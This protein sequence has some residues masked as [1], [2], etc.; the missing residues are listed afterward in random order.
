MIALSEVSAVRKENLVHDDCCQT[1]ASR[2]ANYPF[3]MLLEAYELELR[4]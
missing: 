4:Y 3:L 2:S 1:L